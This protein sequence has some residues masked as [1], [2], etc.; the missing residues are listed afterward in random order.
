[1][2]YVLSIAFFVGTS[3]LTAIAQ[4]ANWDQWRGPNKNGSVESAK[5]PIEWSLEKNIAWKADVPGKGSSTPIVHGNQVIVLTAFKTDRVKEGA[6]ADQTTSGN[7]PPAA[8]GPGNG[9]GTGTRGR[10]DGGGRLE[11]GGGPGR[12][13]PGGGGPGGG[14]AKISVFDHNARSSNFSSN[15]TLRRS[16]LLRLRDDRRECDRPI[17]ASALLVRINSWLMVRMEEFPCLEA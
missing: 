8:P 11:G 7:N 16:L 4:D 13:G 9:I 12:G 17:R 5:P 3:A 10:P 1:M 14:G 2:K 6:T 15:I